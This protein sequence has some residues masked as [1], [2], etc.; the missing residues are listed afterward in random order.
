[1]ETIGLPRLARSL[2]TLIGYSRIYYL[3]Q[4]NARFPSVKSFSAYHLQGKLL[5]RS[6]LFE[7]LSSVK[8]A[9]TSVD[10]IQTALNACVYVQDWDMLMNLSQIPEVLIPM[11]YARLPELTVQ[12]LKVSLIVPFTGNLI[13]SV[14]SSSFSI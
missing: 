4:Y 7:T 3:F 12:E 10:E 6:F 5:L 2:I 8:I 14:V 1:M 13:F 9:F 11:A